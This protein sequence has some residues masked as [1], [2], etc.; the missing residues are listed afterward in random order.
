MKLYFYII[1]VYGSFNGIKS[2]ECEVVEK[3][4]TY[5]PVDKFPNGF[6]MSYVRKDDIGH[7]SGY[8]S[9]IVITTEPNFELA[10][11]L[12]KEKIIKEIERLKK[13]IE[14]EENKLKVIEESEENN[15][16]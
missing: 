5:R 13:S 1:D 14:K 9:N 12:F 6:Y 10:K 8:S 11:R 3:A 2:A 4:K 16:D 7:I 15:Y